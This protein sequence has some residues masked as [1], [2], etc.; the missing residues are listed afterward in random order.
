V[1]QTA[2]PLAHATG[3]PISIE[4]GLS[5][6]GHVPGSIV[7]AQQRFAY[8]PEIDITY[9]PLHT[10]PVPERDSSSPSTPLFLPYFRR[11]LSTAAQLQRVHDGKTIA[12]FS[13][14]A[15]VALV[16]ALT[17]SSVA[18]AGRFAPCGIFKLVK[19]GTATSW[20]VEQHGGDNS[21]HCSQN[22][23]TTFPWCFSDSHD[24]EVVE[25]C[26]LEAK[27]LGPL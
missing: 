3:I 14:A 22:T 10:V 11:I 16:A 19:D 15:S 21:S 8:F 12:C 2:H 1:I 27:R 5:E 24:P 26:W 23:T 17:C 4:D 9:S 7:P 25:A 20:R 6:L 13:H 18:E